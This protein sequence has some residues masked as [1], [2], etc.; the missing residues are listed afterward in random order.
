MEKHPITYDKLPLPD[1]FQLCILVPFDGTQQTSF[2]CTPS[3]VMSTT[4]CFTVPIITRPPQTKPSKTPTTRTTLWR[5]WA[6]HSGQGQRQWGWQVATGL[7]RSR[8]EGTV[9][10]EGSGVGGTGGLCEGLGWWVRRRGMCPPMSWR[11]KCG[12]IRLELL[13]ARILG[14]DRLLADLADTCGC[15]H[16]FWRTISKI[17]A[18]N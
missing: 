1:S 12:D 13:I 8:S 11:V 4:S 16:C 6:G 9:E 14:L 3:T 18:D 10:R 7:G 15:V 2:S 17:H 5:S